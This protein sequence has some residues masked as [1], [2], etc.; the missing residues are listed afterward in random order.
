[1][2]RISDARMSGTAFGT[3]VLHVAPEAAVGGTLALTGLE[4]GVLKSAAEEMNRPLES[5]NRDDVKISYAHQIK[6]SPDGVDIHWKSGVTAGYTAIV[7]WQ[8][9]PKIGLVLLANRGKMKSLESTGKRL[10]SL[11]SH[12]I[13]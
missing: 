5:T 8:T 13:Y 9:K 4:S 12:Q 7:L 6:R 11:I 10:I 2:I 3:V 1:M